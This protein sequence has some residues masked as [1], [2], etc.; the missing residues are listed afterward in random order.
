MTVRLITILFFANALI[1]TGLLWLADNLAPNLFWYPI[2]CGLV[3]GV[4]LYFWA[5][6]T[7]RRE[8]ARE[9]LIGF[10]TPL[11]D[12]DRILATDPVYAGH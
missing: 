11:E 10:Q 6:W 5:I 1:W 2:G 12:A 3:I 9:A 4:A 7:A 8:G